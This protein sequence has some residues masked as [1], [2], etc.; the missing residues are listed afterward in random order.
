MNAFLDN[1]GR[2]CAR[3]HWEV[4]VAW[5]IVFGALLGLRSAFGG[6]YLND[7]KVSGSQSAQGLA[8]LRKDFPSQGGYAGQIVFHA[9]NGTVAAQ[10]T[11]VNTAMTNVAKLPHV[12]S[13]VSPFAVANSPQ[14]AN[15]GTTAYGTASWDVVTTSLDT[16][17]LKRL[18][19]AV[20]PA[21]AAGLQVEYGGAAGQIGQTTDDKNPR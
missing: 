13:A 10:T 16:S 11:A 14:V 5:V 20:A 2:W 17:Y 21:R 12:I 19:G 8:L 15:N 4:I 3:R 6:H 18:D 1:V 9:P 7:Y